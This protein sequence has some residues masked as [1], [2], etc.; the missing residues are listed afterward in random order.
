M[1]KIL[2]K[3]NHIA[4]ECSAKEISLCGGIG[5]CDECG[6][7]AKAGYLVPVLNH[8]MCEECFNDWQSYAKHYAEDDEFERRYADYYESVIPLEGDTI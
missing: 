6:K 8:W 1:K 7:Q 3:S 5:I 2:T 4:Y